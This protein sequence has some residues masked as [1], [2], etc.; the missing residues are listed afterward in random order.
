M[1][2][3]TLASRPTLWPRRLARDEAATGPARALLV[4]L[5][6]LAALAGERVDDRRHA[7][8]PVARLRLQQ[9]RRRAVEGRA[10]DRPL[11]GPQVGA[12]AAVEEVLDLRVGREA[13]GVLAVL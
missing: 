13:V 12:V 6:L 3:R 1:R 9:R 10:D 8:V 4:A 7:L 2:S 11:V 5:G